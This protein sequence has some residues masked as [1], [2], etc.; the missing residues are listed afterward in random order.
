MTMLFGCNTENKKEKIEGIDSNKIVK[1]HSGSFA[2]CGA[3]GAV[4]TGRK[5]IVQGKEYDEGCAICPVLHGPSISNLAMEGLSQ[6]FGKF[7]VSE[8]FKTPDGTNQTVWSYFGTTIR[9]PQYHSLI[10]QLSNGN[11]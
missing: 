3:S 1:V 5:I 11:L 2:F 6:S 4:P 8:N 7:N 10:H 9:Q